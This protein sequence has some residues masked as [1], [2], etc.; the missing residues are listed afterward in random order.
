VLSLTQWHHVACTWDG[1]WMRI[2]VDG[3][4]KTSQAVQADAIHHTPDNDLFIGQY[5]DDNET[6]PFAGK[7]SDVR[8]WS[9][10]RTAEQVNACK[11][12]RLTGGEPG[13]VGYWPLAEIDANGQN[14]S[15]NGNHGTVR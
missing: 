7:I 10:A 8:L 4:E 3:Q 13:L 9:A 11:D 15:P 14:A 5:K 12:V 6:Y 1:A 2:Y